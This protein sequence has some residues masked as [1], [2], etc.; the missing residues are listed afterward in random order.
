[1]TP[2]NHEDSARL[3]ARWATTP[4]NPLQLTQHVGVLPRGYRWTLGGRSF[5][6]LG[7]AASI[8][9]EYRRH[10]QT[11]WPTEIPTPEDVAAVVT[12]GYAD[13]I[14]THDAPRPGTPAGQS[15]RAQCPRSGSRWSHT[16]VYA[17]VVAERISYEEFPR[18]LV[19]G[20]YPARD[21]A[22]GPDGREVISL[23]ADLQAGN[24]VLP[25]LNDLS[26]T[27]GTTI[28]RQ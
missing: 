13:V 26:H 20:H 23:G 22:V 27:W 2:G 24:V 6:S 17:A 12:G 14:L 11:C 10:G 21:E 3:D 28:P 5:V 7:V 18:L 8:D 25:D 9:F 19:H 4:G 15:A 16:A 1:M